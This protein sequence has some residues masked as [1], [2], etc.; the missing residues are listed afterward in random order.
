MIPVIRNL[1]ALKLS[2]LADHPQFV[3]IV[4]EWVHN[5]WGQ[6]ETDATIGT[7]ISNLQSQLNTGIP[8]VALV[9]LRKG[10]PIA[11]SSIKIRELAAFSQYTYWLGSV[12]VLPE[13]RNQGIGA[14]VVENSSRIASE[15]G[16][17]ELF[18]YTHSHENFYSHL[19]FSVVEQPYYQDREIVIMRRSLP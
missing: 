3:P 16:I 1:S 14:L 2:Y 10:I 7:S 19:G 4:A 11:C 5:E 18:L 8:P 9:M 12:Y 15:L 17:R 6:Q 13:F